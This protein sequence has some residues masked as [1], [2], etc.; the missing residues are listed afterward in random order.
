MRTLQLTLVAALLI[1]AC[2]N[3]TSDPEA[4]CELLADSVD[5]SVGTQLVPLDDP[6][7]VAQN[8]TLYVDLF[9]EMQ[10]IAPKPIKSDLIKLRDFMTD[11][12]DAKERAN[13]ERMAEIAAIQQVV[14]NTQGLQAATAR[15]SAYARNECGLTL[16]SPLP[17]AGADTTTPV[18]S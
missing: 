8:M 16:A 3:N 1:A 14:E 12:R 10:E 9:D 4:L 7:E 18:T 11:I 6:V 2:S 15:V 5:L 17:G 13:G